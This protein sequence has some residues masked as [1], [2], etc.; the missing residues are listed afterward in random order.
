MLAM[1]SVLELNC[2]TKDRSA[3]YGDN[4]GMLM[5]VADREQ[6]AKL[7]ERLVDERILHLAASKMR[8][9]TTSEEEQ[10][11]IKEKSAERAAAIQKWLNGCGA[12]SQQKIAR[13]MKEVDLHYVAATFP[14]ISPNAIAR[15]IKISADAYHQDPRH[16]HVINMRQDAPGALLLDEALTSERTDQEIAEKLVSVN[17][18]NFWL[19][20]TPTQM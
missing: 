3:V 4:T 6:H 15:F 9:S 14:Q 1:L 10:Q 5:M 20:W 17:P 8:L 7:Y 2:L 11:A 18:E 16:T 13:F 19:V 12:E